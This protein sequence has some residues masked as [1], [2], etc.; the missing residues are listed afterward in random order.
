MK[1]LLTIAI[2]CT[3]LVCSSAVWANDFT[4]EGSFDSDNNLVKISGV[5]ETGGG[6]VTV[7]VLSYNT[8]EKTL[9]LEDIN[10]GGAM[11]NMSHPDKNGNFSIE[12][13]MMSN[14]DGGL[15]KAIV[16]REDKQS[17]TRFSYANSDRAMSAIRLLNSAGNASELSGVIS[18]NAEKLGVNSELFAKYSISISDYMYANR[19]DSGYTVDLFLNEYTAVLALNMVKSGDKS[20]GDVVGMFSSYLGVDISQDYDAY[21]NTVKSETER[22]VKVKDIDVSAEEFYKECLLLAR[23][24]KAESNVVL[25]KLM[26]DNKTVLGLDMTN[27]NKIT[28]DYA[29]LSVF[30]NMLGGSYVKYE[31]AAK[32]FK[33]KSLNACSD[34]D[35]NYSGNSSGGGGGG[36]SYGG[37]PIYEVTDTDDNEP[38]NNSSFA[39]MQSHWAADSV[40]KLTKLGAVGGFPDGSF[41]P[42]QSVTRAEFSKI[43]CLA[44]GFE[45]VEFDL[46]FDDVTE[47]DWFYSYVLSLAK[48]NIITGYDGFF[49]PNDMITRQDAAV[50]T[51][52]ALQKRGIEFKGGTEFSDSDKISDYA[53]LAVSELSGISVLNGYNGE[54][55]PTDSLTRAEAATVL[56]NAITVCDR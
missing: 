38:D 6:E 10:S 55:H 53:K 26:L 15:Y 13:G 29:K 11:F 43:L 34:N 22:L 30:G 36:G 48:Q 4:T 51:H 56:C 5:T 52:R 21:S 39:D 16:Y 2:V 32:D 28:S 17:E 40:E 18:E 44:L 7:V 3:S 8:D 33:E 46:M 42:E 37:S 19:P 24:N 41:M 45:P 1:K 50:I 9:T 14:L 12:M 27:Y 49:N 25:Q 20:L 23:I 54:F 47:S 31:D 35:N